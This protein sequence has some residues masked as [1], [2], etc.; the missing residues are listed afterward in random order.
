MTGVSDAGSAIVGQIRTPS[1]DQ[2]DSRLNK[3]YGDIVVDANTNS[4]NVT[5]TPGFNNHSATG[6]AFTL[7]TASRL[8]TPFNVYT[9]WYTARNISIDLGWST[10]TGGQ[11]FFL[12]EPRWHEEGAPVSALS[13]EI[14]ESNFG[15]NGYLY[16]GD[17]YLAHIST[18]NLS[19]IFT[20]DEVAQTTITIAHSAGLLDKTYIRLPVMKGKMF[21][22][23]LS[24]TTAFRVHGK[25][26]EL[27][28]KQWGAGGPWQTIPMF[29]DMATSEKAS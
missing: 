23:R 6:T 18:V 15:L 12:W 3:L 17:M 19:L 24:S 21:R 28:V 2:G 1:R 5:A 9:E 16:T 4:V 22:I 14:C 10:T 8:L 27:R 13:W 25:E 7:N 11:Q 26:S 29:A 20:V